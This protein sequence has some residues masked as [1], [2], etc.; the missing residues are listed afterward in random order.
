VDLVVDEVGDLEEVIIK[1]L[2]EEVL[3]EIGKDL[4]LIKDP[5][6]MMEVEILGREIVEMNE[7]DS[8]EVMGV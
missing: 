6:L 8:L 3:V 1:V 7:A 5:V 4:H 2:V